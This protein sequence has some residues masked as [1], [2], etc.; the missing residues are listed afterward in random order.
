MLHSSCPKFCALVDPFSVASGLGSHA[1]EALF[2]E[3][4]SSTKHGRIY[5]LGS[6]ASSSASH[7]MMCSSQA[8]LQTATYLNALD[9]SIC[10]LLILLARPPD[11]ARARGFIS[12]AVCTPCSSAHAPAGV[13]ATLRTPDTSPVYLLASAMS[14]NA[15]PTQC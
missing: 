10:H 5:H 15:T 9:D 13:S 8:V 1:Q 14:F 6:A 7:H 2:L 4:V 12:R 11:S 3:M